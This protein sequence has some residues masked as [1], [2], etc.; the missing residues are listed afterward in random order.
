LGTGQQS[1]SPLQVRVETAN[2]YYFYNNNGSSKLSVYPLNI[3]L[4]LL[5]LGGAAFQETT[6]KETGNLIK[7]RGL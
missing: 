2:H 6:G 5:R 1:V 7:E 3:Q 4:L